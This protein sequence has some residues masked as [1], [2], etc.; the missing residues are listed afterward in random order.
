MTKRNT[1]IITVFIIIVIMG[2]VCL[3][4]QYSSNS[5]PILEAKVTSDNG[6]NLSFFLKFI[7][8]EKFEK[9][10]LQKDNLSKL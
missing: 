1:V 4:N 7:I 9:I 8:M 10:H 3:H 2:L 5:S 6:D